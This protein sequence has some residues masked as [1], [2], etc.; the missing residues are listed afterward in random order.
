[1]LAAG[2]L[3]RWRT[4]PAGDPFTTATSVLAPGLRDGMPVMLKI[5]TGDEE[6]RGNALMTW[7][8][9]RGAAR[10]LEHDD[11][12]VLLERA[13]GVRS[14]AA[15]ARESADGDD[16]ATRTLCLV[17]TRLHELDDVPPAGLIGLREWFRELF[18]HADAAG[19]FHA[20]AAEIALDLLAEE[21]ETVVLHGDLH[22]GNV[23][24]FGAERHP[25]TDGWLAID[26]KYLTGDRAFDFTNILC[27]PSADVAARP[28]R[29]SRQVEV[30]CSATGIDRRRLLRWTV[31][32]CGLSSAWIQRDAA[33]AD[34][35]PTGSPADASTLAIGREAQRLLAPS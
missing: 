21:R 27:N 14:L 18:A 32:W 29:L 30:I 3:R 8:A 10:V 15:M 11:R 19:G 34:A 25:Q 12:A 6:R 5:A 24:D 17:G 13:T 28:E 23:L 22:H 31:A 2:Y 9:G 33:A 7:W 16:A 35:P 1:M 26:P 4:S 20:R